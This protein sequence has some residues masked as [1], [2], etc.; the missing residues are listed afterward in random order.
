M[1]SRPRHRVEGRTIVLHGLLQRQARTTQGGDVRVEGREGHVVGVHGFFS[2]LLSPPKEEKVT[3]K[4]EKAAVLHITGILSGKLVWT[5]EK[6]GD[7]PAPPKEEPVAKPEG[8]AVLLP[9]TSFFSGKD[10]ATQGGPDLAEGGEGH[11]V[12]L[13]ELLQ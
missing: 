4:Q 2:N 10:R 13:H 11:V 6:T 12:A 7:R 8:T 9:F 1:R 5:K 3:P